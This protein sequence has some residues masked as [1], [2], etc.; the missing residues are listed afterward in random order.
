MKIKKATVPSG[1]AAHIINHG[2]R[3][4]H[5]THS[6]AH[7]RIHRRHSSSLFFFLSDHA[8]S[9]QEHTCD[10]SS[11]LQCYASYLS[12]VDYTSLAQILETV[13]TSVVTEVAL[14]FL[15][16]LNDNGTFLTSVSY[17]LAKRLLDSALNDLDTCSLVLPS[18]A[19]IARI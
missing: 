19:S 11:V 1:T 9:S 17:D 12:W 5:T 13:L 16:F 15:H 4:H 2:S 18:N 7:T 10:R 14:A 8:L 6:A 3:L